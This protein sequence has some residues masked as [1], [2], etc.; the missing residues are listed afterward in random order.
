ML[1]YKLGQNGHRWK[2]PAAGPRL[3]TTIR[4]RQ[5]SPGGSARTPLGRHA[6][7]GSVLGCISF[8]STS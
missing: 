1:S 3:A 2:R 8:H 7:R 4:W 6:G 5:E